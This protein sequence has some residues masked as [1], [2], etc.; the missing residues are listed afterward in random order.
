M[1]LLIVALCGIPAY[2]LARTFMRTW[3]RTW[4]RTHG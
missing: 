4:E 2:T 1:E 3:E